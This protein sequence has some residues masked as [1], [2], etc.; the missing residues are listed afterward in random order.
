M[1]EDKDEPTE[2]MGIPRPSNRTKGLVSSAAFVGGR[3]HKEGRDE[4]I[5]VEVWHHN[6]IGQ[7]Y[8]WRGGNSMPQYIYPL[9]LYKKIPERGEK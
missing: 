8:V 7:P 9:S 4:W 1:I 5:E 2:V 6:S 3:V